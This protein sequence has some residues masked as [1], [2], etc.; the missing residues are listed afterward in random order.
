LTE[1]VCNNGMNAKSERIIE[2]Q[3]DSFPFRLKDVYVTARI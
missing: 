1:R 2:G 3:I